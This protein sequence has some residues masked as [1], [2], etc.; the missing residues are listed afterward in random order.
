MPHPQFLQGNQTFSEIAHVRCFNSNNEL[1]F[2]KAKY[3]INNYKIKED[4][5]NRI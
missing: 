3:S 1:F 5:L 2:S 4:S